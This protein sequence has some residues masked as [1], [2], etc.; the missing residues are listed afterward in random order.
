[1]K[2]LLV[3][4]LS[5]ALVFTLA[6][7]QDEEIDYTEH[8]LTVYF[9]PSRPA[10]EILT[11]TAP[12]EQMLLEELADAGYDLAGVDII[13]SSSYEAA[14]EAMLSGTADVGFLP[15]GTYIMYADVDDSP[16]DVILTATRAGLQKDSTEAKDWNDGEATGTFNWQVG[17]Y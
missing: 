10:D 4:F 15:G 14:G 17:Y 2:K 8:T 12:L 6:G 1:M 16:V 7:C 13:V 5:L 11:I 9:V 3:L